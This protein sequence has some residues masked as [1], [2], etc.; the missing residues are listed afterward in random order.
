[1]K[2]IKK[3]IPTNPYNFKRTQEA[4][5]PFIKASRVLIEDELL[6][7][8]CQGGR[9]N[10]NGTNALGDVV[11]EGGYLDIECLLKALIS[12]VVKCHS[13][14]ESLKKVVE[15]SEIV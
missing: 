4:N 1:M 3:K 9:R 8:A 13:E 10:F 11:T 7:S 6:L 5:L 14:I 15:N 12:E 2:S